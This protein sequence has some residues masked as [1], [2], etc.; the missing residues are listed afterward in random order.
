M[1]VLLS[2][3]ESLSMNNPSTGRELQDTTIT[4]TIDEVREINKKLIERKYL[5]NIVNEQDSV[6]KYQ[7]N[8]INEEKRIVKELQDQLTSKVIFQNQLN[9]T[10]KRQKV[11]SV[12][13]GV[14]LAISIIGILLK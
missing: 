11:I 4:I 8:Y 1:I 6:I 7:D 5:L 2:Y 10:L 12:C 13:L 3:L 9:N 14:S